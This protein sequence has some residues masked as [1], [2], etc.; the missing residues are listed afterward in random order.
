MFESSSLLPFPDFLSLYINI[1]F[2]T[3]TERNNIK[4][5]V[6]AGE[7]NLTGSRKKY[8][9]LLTMQ[10]L[11]PVPQKRKSEMLKKLQWLWKDQL[12]PIM[13]ILT[14][15]KASVFYIMFTSCL[16]NSKHI[17]ANIFLN[18]R[19][20][21]KMLNKLVSLTFIRLLLKPL[22]PFCKAYFCCGTLE[23]L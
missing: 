17:V 23:I 2:F 4:C 7:Q 16:Q 8:I 1:N 6:L 3:K 14:I 21:I 11:K 18:F 9:I 13:I 10:F 5:L 12:A 22:F 19:I 15:S 20:C